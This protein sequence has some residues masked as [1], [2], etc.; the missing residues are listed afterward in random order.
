M[1]EAIK[2]I[3]QGGNVLRIFENAETGAIKLTFSNDVLNEACDCKWA[4]PVRVF[5]S[6]DLDFLYNSFRKSEFIRKLVYLVQ[7][8]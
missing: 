8:R 1:N 6:G 7:S 4:M 2:R 5:L 3:K